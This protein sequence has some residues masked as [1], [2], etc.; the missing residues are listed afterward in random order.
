M[1]LP[2]H[3]ASLNLLAPSPTPNPSPFRTLYPGPVNGDASADLEGGVA[4]GL[5]G[6]DGFLEESLKQHLDL[7]I[8]ADFKWSE[9]DESG[10]GLGE[11]KGDGHVAAVGSGLEEQSQSVAAGPGEKDSEEEEDDG[12][13]M[14]YYLSKVKGGRER[15]V[16]LD[17][18]LG[19]DTVTPSGPKAASPEQ[20]QPQ[21]SSA[22][23]SNANPSAQ[24]HAA[25]P[26][27]LAS[28]L[29]QY[30]SFLSSPNPPIPTLSAPDGRGAGNNASAPEDGIIQEGSVVH[31]QLNA[32]LAQFFAQRNGLQSG[33]QSE[34][35]SHSHTHPQSQSQAQPH[36]QGRVHAVPPPTPVISN[37]ST[38]TDPATAAQN[39]MALLSSAFPSAFANGN[40]SGSGSVPGTPMINGG[41]SGYLQQTPQLGG[42]GGQRP[43]QPMRQL[44][45][46]NVWEQ[47]PG[48]GGLSHPS[49]VNLF[50][51]YQQQQSTSVNGN[52]SGSGAG[53]AG[54]FPPSIH[55]P[56]GTSVMDLEVLSNQS[57]SGSDKETPNLPSQQYPIRSGSIAV[58]PIAPSGGSTINPSHA[59][60]I[61]AGQPIIDFEVDDEVNLVDVADL[62]VKQAAEAGPASKKRKTVADEAEEKEE[63]ARMD[64]ERRYAAGEKITP[65]E[66][67]RRRNTAAS[68]R[69][70]LKKKERER[71]MEMKAKDLEIKL[72]RMEREME[73]LRKENGWLKALVINGAPQPFSAPPMNPASLEAFV[74]A[75]VAAGMHNHNIGPGVGG[76]KRKRL[77]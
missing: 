70:R 64:I 2:S 54:I 48:G 23:S 30:S 33:Q 26:T 52:G 19:L 46:P 6:D 25:A 55:A 22:P 5:G 67:K 40:G 61:I 50:N 3:I 12:G 20:P 58:P 32:H 56:S 53:S 72:E 8:N 59:N 16:L 76:G 37:K 45:M 1:H 75:E 62:E 29:S 35:S 28:F 47:F 38:P 13:L 34:K 65:E 57:A 68:A 24:T 10:V 77:D 17:Q 14:R 69:F 11:Y 15:N 63:A 49:Q 7:W 74:Q 9:G 41:G 18:R 31:E 51:G 39:M 36:G 4:G 60:A 43:Q 21:T 71:A 44:S 66:D 42:G 73:S 27:D